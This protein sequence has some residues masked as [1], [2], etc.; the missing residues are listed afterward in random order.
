[1]PTTISEPSTSTL[2]AGNAT[3]D[4]TS[5]L[6]SGG[7]ESSARDARVLV[8]AALGIEAAQLI[9][10]PERPVGG[11]E[12]AQLERFISRRLSREPVSRILGTRGFYGREFD[13]SPATLDPRPDSETLI[14]AA[15]LL[16]D[17]D[18]AGRGPPLRILDVGTGSG[19]LLVTLLAE[20]PNA[21][22]LGT[23]ISPE[24][25]QVAQHNARSHGVTSRADWKMAR[26]L[27]GIGGV[28]D[29][30]VA[31]P[32]YVPTG[33]IEHLEPE[34]RE[35]DPRSALDG[36]ADGLDVYREIAKDLVEIVPS[37]WALFEV[38][39]D[40]AEAVADLLGSARVGAQRPEVRT[41]RDLNG[42]DRCVAWKARP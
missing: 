1:M 42:V 37:G 23:D 7:I 4:T 13:I 38:G 11:P 24:A 22:G 35:Y 2:T 39:R 3:V 31:N 32:P 9:S 14:D 29:L 16:V 10:R 18:E 12:R 28:F 21:S 36:G 6:R 33:M 27:N 19:C 20:L 5:R 25:L 15:L 26:S 30:L 34:V 40:Q 17:H 41:F 8:A